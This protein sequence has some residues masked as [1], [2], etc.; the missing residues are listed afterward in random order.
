MKDILSW[1]KKN[2]VFF[3]LFAPSFKKKKAKFPRSDKASYEILPKEKWI[4][5]WHE[6]RTFFA[7]LISGNA[8]GQYFS[9]FFYLQHT[10]LVVEQFDGTPSCNLIVIIPKLA[11][12][13]ELFQ[14]THGCRCIP[15]ENHCFRAWLTELLCIISLLKVI[16]Y[17]IKIVLFQGAKIRKQGT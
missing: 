1:I 14:G 11:E 15:V 4:M 13:L 3:V 12:P 17:N 2:F 10:S 6:N 7:F 8:S 9:T 16:K 5:R